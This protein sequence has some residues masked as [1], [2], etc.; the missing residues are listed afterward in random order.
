M[1][2]LTIFA[3]MLAAAGIPFVWLTQLVRGGR[4]GLALTIGSLIGAALAVAMFAAGRPFGVDPVQAMG[5]AMLLLLPALLG[6]MAGGVLGWML[7]KR[8]DRAL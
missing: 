7:R 8:D 5:L 1:A 6:C 2:E 4:S 3:I